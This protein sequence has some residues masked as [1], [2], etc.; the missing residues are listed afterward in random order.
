MAQ[1]GLPGGG[2]HFLQ[3]NPHDEG[4][5]GED[6]RSDGPGGRGGKVPFYN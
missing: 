5:S 6:G 2:D 4:I 3:V 1:A